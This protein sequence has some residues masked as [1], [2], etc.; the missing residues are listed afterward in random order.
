MDKSTFLVPQNCGFN[1]A[2]LV[3][4]LRVKF[5]KDTAKQVAAVLKIKSHR[6]VENWLL[7]VSCPGFY[8]VG[9]MIAAWGPEFI[10][11][12]MDEPPEW[13]S[14]ALAREELA[15]LGRRTAALKARLRQP[16]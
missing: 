15:E 9:Q 16:D 10:A 5:P 1:H 14:E 13:A 6:T 8:N 7:E 12:V 3:D 4:Y 2:K 11:A